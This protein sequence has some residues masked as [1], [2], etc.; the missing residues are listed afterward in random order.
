MNKNLKD[1]II[2][3]LKHAGIIC[4]LVIVAMSVGFVLGNV[5]GVLFILFGKNILWGIIPTL[6]ALVLFAGW[7]THHR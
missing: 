4:G 6:I 2:G 3:T 5:L 7:Y 1:S